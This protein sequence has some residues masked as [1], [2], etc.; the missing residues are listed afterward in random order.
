MDT[1][2]IYVLVCFRL[3]WLVCTVGF[4]CWGV[5]GGERE[6]ERERLI[7]FIIKKAFSARRTS[8]VE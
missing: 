7:E 6:R 1:L 8:E 4:R 2:D 3:V 5:E